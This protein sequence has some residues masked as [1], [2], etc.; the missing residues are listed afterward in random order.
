[1]SP[2]VELVPQ[3]EQIVALLGIGVA[4]GAGGGELV[5]VAHADQ[6]A[7]DEPAEAG[8][9]GHDVAPQVGRGGVAVLED[10]RRAGAGVD[11][12]HAAAVDV[13]E[14]LGGVGLGG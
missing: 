10:D 12:G 14:F 5:A 11:V 13:G 2:S 1:M 3:R 9:V 4:V 7:G 6:V 8:A